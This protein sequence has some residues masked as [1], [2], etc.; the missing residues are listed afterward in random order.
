MAVARGKLDKRALRHTAGRA[1]EAGMVRCEREL[2]RAHARPGLSFELRP[3]EVRGL[4]RLRLLPRVALLLNELERGIV[5]AEER[6][7]TRRQWLQR[8]IHQRHCE[9][10]AHDAIPRARPLA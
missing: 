2:R 3:E 6:D 8:M 4:L 1:K 7:A 5:E 9:L 10:G